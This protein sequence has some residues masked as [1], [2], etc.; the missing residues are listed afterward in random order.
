MPSTEAIKWSLIK[1]DYSSIRTRAIWSAHTVPHCSVQ[2]GYPQRAKL[3]LGCIVILV[4]I[5]LTFN[6]RNMQPGI[7]S[8]QNKDSI[9]REMFIIKFWQACQCFL[10]EPYLVRKTI[11]KN[12]EKHIFQDF[13]VPLEQLKCSFFFFFN[14]NCYTVLDHNIHPRIYWHVSS[15][16]KQKINTWQFLSR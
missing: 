2:I 6:C 14:K 7:S 16:E 13:E 5:S 8:P 3:G 9:F 10:P 4:F 1:N 12:K 15:D 11:L